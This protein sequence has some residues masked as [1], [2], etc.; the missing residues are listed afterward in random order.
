MKGKGCPQRTGEKRQTVECELN[1]WNHIVA[2]QDQN[3]C[4]LLKK[5]ASPSQTKGSSCQKERGANT[6][7]FYSVMTIPRPVQTQVV[8]ADASTT[9]IL[10]VSPAEPVLTALTEKKV[11]DL[12]ED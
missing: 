12:R 9:L 6:P 11:T 4:Y 1:H 10:Q 2:R 7:G 3:Q 5:S 8:N